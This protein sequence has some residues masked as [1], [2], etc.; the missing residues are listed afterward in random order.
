MFVQSIQCFGGFGQWGD[1]L[2]IV[3]AAVYCSFYST[4]TVTKQPHPSLRD[5][6]QIIL[7]WSEKCGIIILI[8][9][10]KI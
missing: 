10:N 9:L 4:I 5:Q 8:K 6:I 7:L 2:C 1:G 3:L